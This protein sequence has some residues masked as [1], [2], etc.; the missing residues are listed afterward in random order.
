[1]E[2]TKWLKPSISG[3]FSWIWR[4]WPA[5]HSG[6]QANGPEAPPPA[7][8]IGRPTAVRTFFPGRE[9]Q[10]SRIPGLRS[11]PRYGPQRSPC[12]KGPKGRRRNQRRAPVRWRRSMKSQD[13]DCVG[14]CH[15]SAL[16]SFLAML[17]GPRGWSGPTR[18]VHHSPR[19][20]PPLFDSPNQ[21]PPVHAGSFQATKGTFFVFPI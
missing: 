8:E 3:F 18:V 11:C 20:G 6:F 2:V 15:E 12:P 5:V 13:R 4:V 7:A 9:G 16:R 10:C 14:F 21:S 19:A 17:G 1:M